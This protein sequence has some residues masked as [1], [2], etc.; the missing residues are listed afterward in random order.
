[1][2]DIIKRPIAVG[3]RRGKI[4]TKSYAKSAL[5]LVQWG[6]HTKKKDEN[7]T[8]NHSAGVLTDRVYIL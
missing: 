6:I 7:K 4:Y 8:K 2:S 5:E 3:K 1:M